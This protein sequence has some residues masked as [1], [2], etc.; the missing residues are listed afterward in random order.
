V[1]VDQDRVLRTAEKKDAIVRIDRDRR[2]IGV[3]ISG[4]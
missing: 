1:L 2:D 3:R 4:G